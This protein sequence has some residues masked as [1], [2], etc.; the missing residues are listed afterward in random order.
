[1]QRDKL[2]P[3]ARQRVAWNAEARHTFR[4]GRN[5]EDGVRERACR[6]CAAGMEI[7]PTA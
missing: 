4:T 5:I 6:N 2:P 1:M 3:A 7:L